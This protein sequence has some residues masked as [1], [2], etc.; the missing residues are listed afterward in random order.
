[1]QIRHKTM[2]VDMVEKYEKERAY[3]EEGNGT[4]RDGEGRWRRMEQELR[5]LP[6]KLPQG[7]RE[8]LRERKAHKILN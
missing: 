6:P 3:V 5:L 4:V 8:I 1:M 7:S 2:A